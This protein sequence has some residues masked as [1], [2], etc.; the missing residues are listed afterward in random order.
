MNRNKTCL[1]THVKSEF[2]AVDEV[3]AYILAAIKAGYTTLAVTDHGS[4][5]G[6]PD[7]YDVIEHEK[8]EKDGNPDIQNFKIIYGC[9]MYVECPPFGMD[10]KIGHL[11]TMATDTTGKHLLDKLVSKATI[12]KNGMPVITMKQLLAVQ[13]KIKGHIIATSACIS[14][15]PAIAL[16]ANQILETKIEREKAKQV[17]CFTPNCKEHL[18]ILKEMNDLEEQISTMRTTRKELVKTRDRSYISKDKKLEKLKNIAPSEEETIEFEKTLLAEKQASKDAVAQVEQMDVDIKASSRLRSQKNDRKKEIENSIEK[19]LRAEVKIDSYKLKMAD[20]SERKE[21]AK[22]EILNYKKIFGEGNY[23]VEVQNHGLEDEA[24]VYPILAQIARETNTPLCAANDAHMPDNSPECMTKRNVARF[25]RFVSVSESDA[26]K[27]MYIK[28]PEELFEW[29]LKI[30]PEDVVNE[31]IANCDIIGERCTYVPEKEEHY[32]VFDKSKDANELLRKAAYDGI[33]FRFPGRVGWTDEYQKRLDY[34]LDVITS[35]GYADYHLIV[36]D[37][38]E[39]ARFVGKV[40]TD[41]LPECPLTIEEA[42]KFVEANGWDIGVGTGIG[43]GSGAGSLVCYNTGITGLDP[44]KYELL[45]ERFLNPERVSMPDIDSDFGNQVREKTIEYVKAKY[46]HEAVVSILTESREGVKGAIRD[47]ARYLGKKIYDDDKRFLSLGDAIRKKC[48]DT[49]N[50]KFKSVVADET[51]CY[52]MLMETYKN[53]QD[54]KDIINLAKDIEGMLTTFGM[55]AAGVIIPD[56]DDITDYIPLRWNSKNK[57]YTTQCDMVQS[58]GAGLLKMDFLGLKTLDIIT[59]ALRYIKQTHGVSIDITKIPF[60]DEVFKCIFAAGLTKNVFQFESAG[61]RSSLTKLGP[62]T[63]L[64]I[65]AM[66][67]LYRPGPMDF[68]PNFIEGKNNPAGIVYDCPQIE[69][70]L[71]PTYGCIVYQEQVMQI[72]RDLAGYSYGRSDLVR[73]AMS[74]KKTAV[75]EKERQN[76]VYGN[77]D[78]NIAG[79]IANGIDEKVANKIYDDMID[80]AKYAFNKSHAAAYSVTSYQTAWLKY[81]YPCEFLCSVLNH[82][83]EIKKIPGVIEDARAFG[84][85]I[86][87][88]DINLSQSDFSITNG[89]I[90]YGLSKVKGVGVASKAIMAAREDKLISSFKDFAL[91]AHTNAGATRA[92]VKAGAFD[93]L[94]YTRASLNVANPAIKDIMDILDNIK[95]K[96]S[97]VKNTEAVMEFVDEYADI[98]SLKKRISDESITFQITSKKVPTSASVKKRINTANEKIDEFLEDLDD[99]EIPFIMEDEDVK[100][101]DEKEVLS[102]YLTGHPMD[103]YVVSTPSVDSIVVGKGRVSG[104]VSDIVVRKNKMDKEWATFTL[105]DR[106]GSINCVAF[107]SQYETLKSTLVEDATLEFTGKIVVDDFRSTEEEEVLSLQAGSA[108]PLSVAQ[109]GY[110]ITARDVIEWQTSFYAQMKECQDDNG[111]VLFVETLNDG[112]VRKASF[113]VSSEIMKRGAKV[114]RY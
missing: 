33:E 23:Y 81:H 113:L 63:I 16:L 109:K 8:A 11:I 60:E 6:L 43:R 38:L 7:I 61:M 28:T 82:T 108:K 112:L 78:E 66:N 102:L 62:E 59:D 29:L 106:T 67:A 64:D 5:A 24:Y 40:P 95:K 98:E 22:E 2:D 73:R 90:I 26:D 65:I 55:H 35:M 25:L 49:P 75:M 84:I 51:T 18:E 53:D 89:K 45:F 92:L 21:A 107:A 103:K 101:S 100:L 34:E 71:A 14:G 41:R 88:P 83:E 85:E 46:G 48:P 104:L 54:A 97:F 57:R 99:I 58:E 36:K 42:K 3:K 72:V 37:F 47:A 76:F 13:D 110:S 50:V 44:I 10:E 12:N 1:H 9:E 105:E 86:L 31:A 77:K 111:T 93:S 39:Y 52:E 56:N 94:D 69:P 27:E 17:D 20:E 68:I 30:L 70:I 87:P 15:A 80:F 114:Y 4:L 96:K 19:F 79:C 32:P 74:K 91:R